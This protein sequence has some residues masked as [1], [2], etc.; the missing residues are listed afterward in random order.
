MRQMVVSKATLVP[1]GV[2]VGAVA[3]GVTITKATDSTATDVATLKVRMGHVESEQEDY[4]KRLTEENKWRLKV[5]E[6][7]GK[8]KGA[9]GVKD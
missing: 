1:L 3:L 4:A 6:D 5:S 7:L 8:I 9:V 2:L